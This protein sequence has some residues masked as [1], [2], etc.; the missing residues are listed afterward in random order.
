MKLTQPPDSPR[1]IRFP[2]GGSA[3]AVIDLAHEHQ[4]HYSHATDKIAVCHAVTP[5]D[6]RPDGPPVLLFYGPDEDPCIACPACP[7]ESTWL[8]GL[9]A[10]VAAAIHIQHAPDCPLFTRYTRSVA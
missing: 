10:C 6:V 5:P 9:P 2:G 7:S 1:R 3:S 8:T 4:P